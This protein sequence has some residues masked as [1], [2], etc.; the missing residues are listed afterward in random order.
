[1]NFFFVFLIFSFLMGIFKSVRLILDPIKAKK[2]IF[3]IYKELNE[4][5]VL[6][7]SYVIT[8]GHYLDKCNTFIYDN[9]KKLL[10][11]KY[12]EN[13]GA[14]DNHNVISGGKYKLCFFTLTNSKFNINL[15]FFTNNEVGAVKELTNESTLLINFS[16]FKRN[17]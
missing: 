9:N 11:E 10:F 5:D 16:R 3:C 14:Y 8:G 12:N 13:R 17:E 6:N 15:E 4:G 7:I 1:M 2:N